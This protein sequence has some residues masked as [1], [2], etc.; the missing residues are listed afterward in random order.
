MADKVLIGHGSGGRLSHSLLDTL[1]GPAFEIEEFLDAAVL[2][3]P[4]Q[5]IAFT[6][7]SY[8]VSPIFFPGGDIGSL[9]VHGTVNDLSVMGAEPLVLSLS[10]ILEEG[11]PLDSLKQIINSIKEAARRA[12]VRIVTG[13]TKVVEKGKGDGIFINTSGIGILRTEVVLSPKNVKPGDRII[14]SS[15]IGEHGLAVMAERNGLGFSQPLISDSRPLNRPILKALERF[16]Q[17]IRVMRDPT[18]GGLAT[19]LKEMAEASGLCIEI[20]EEAIPL[21]SQVLGACDILGLDPLYVASEGVFV[22]VV[23]PDISEEMVSFLRTFQECEGAAL[24]GQVKQ[25]PPSMVLLMTKMG[26]TRVVDMLTGEQLPR[27][28]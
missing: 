18:R 19:I 23:S 20:N 17:K 6:T 4:T 21:R 24:I 22:A 12:G 16:G 3:V 2:D 26:G 11:F 9:A 27:I 25:K 5:R 14:V 28:C 10:L 15:Y 1:I 13:D 8:V 7:D